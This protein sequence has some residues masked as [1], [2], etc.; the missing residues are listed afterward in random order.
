M[1]TKILCILL[2]FSLTVYAQSD[3]IKRLETKRKALLVEIE[4]NRKLLNENIANTGNLNTR[5]SLLR[6]QI[7]S[8]LSMIGLLDEE[9]LRIDREISFKELQIKRQEEELQQ[10]KNDYS[11]TV[12][13]MYMKRNKKNKLLFILSADDF[14]QAIRRV[15]YLREYSGYHQKQA[16]EIEEKQNRLID[17]K[18]LLEKKKTDKIALLEERKKEEQQLA[19]E[20]NNLKEEA[21]VLDGKKK[22]I[23]AELSKKQKEEQKIN[24]E[25]QRIVA[26]EIARAE[27]E[28]A[29]REAAERA[30]RERLAQQQKKD[31]LNKPVTTAQKENA[32]SHT[33]ADAALSANFTDNKGKIPYPLKGEYKIVN[34]F[35]KNSS[36]SLPLFDYKGI[37]ILTLSGTN[38]ISIFD[39]E[40]R[41]VGMIN[42]C[43]YILIMHGDYYSSYV[44]LDSSHI[45]VKTG[46]KVKKGQALGRILT[47]ATK[48]GDTILHFELH[49]KK[50]A[51]NPELWLIR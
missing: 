2:L 32:F 9:V 14:S 10:K 37:D 28:K 13:Y 45:Y 31:S 20:E 39:G 19:G 51:L 44:N 8:R 42:H 40:V 47:D 33:K 25:I 22:E 7:K 4:T 43:W 26:E 12:R 48:G 36:N 11:E 46:D 17:E 16:K 50:T 18:S 15:V 34:R 5:L 1:K 30:E 35:G 27:R 41:T 3:E 21:K 49:K 29:A 24:M 6:D 23:Q 38:A